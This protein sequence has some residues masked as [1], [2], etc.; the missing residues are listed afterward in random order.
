MW[1]SPKSGQTAIALA[2]RDRMA[3]TAALSSTKPAAPRLRRKCACRPDPAHS[4]F[5]KAPRGAPQ[6]SVRGQIAWIDREIA[7]PEFQ[8]AACG[9]GDVPDRHQ[10]RHFT[11]SDVKNCSTP[12]LDDFSFIRTLVF[13]TS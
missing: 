9:R 11:D 8:T 6:R 5:V 7:A 1:L 2:P 4:P 12:T 13:A 3:K 10:A